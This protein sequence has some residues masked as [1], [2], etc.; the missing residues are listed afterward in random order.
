MNDSALKVVESL[1][2]KYGQVAMVGDGVNDAPALG[3]ATL[4]IASCRA[5]E[6]AQRW[7]YGSMPLEPL[8]HVGLTP[9]LQM[10]FIP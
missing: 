1:V 7:R 10:I 5:A 8:V 6:A 4:G 3:R 2:A 9:V